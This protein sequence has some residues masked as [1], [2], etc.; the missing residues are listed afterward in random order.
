M[1]IHVSFLF[2]SV[3]FCIFLKIGIR[4]L[5]K[6]L[7][8]KFLIKAFF[9]LLFKILLPSDYTENALI[10]RDDLKIHLVKFHTYYIFLFYFEK[11]IIFLKQKP[12]KTFSNSDDVC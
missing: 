1:L 11:I 2:S 3:L 12:M 9:M 4:N 6:Q 10:Y 5:T 7:I 8:L